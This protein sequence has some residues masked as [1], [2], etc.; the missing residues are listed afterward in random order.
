MKIKLEK[1]IKL[2]DLSTEISVIEGQV[3]VSLEDVNKI[4]DLFKD[5]VKM[6]EEH[7]ELWLK[8]FIAI[9]DLNDADALLA[10]YNDAKL[11]VGE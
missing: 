2:L 7:R 3:W 6:L 5:K 9:M 1:L 8:R 10:L 11:L 4:V